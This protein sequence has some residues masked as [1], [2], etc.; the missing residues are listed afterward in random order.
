MN[1]EK[2]GDESFMLKFNKNI[3]DF[4]TIEKSLEAYS[5]FMFF[6]FDE[7]ETYFKLTIKSLDTNFKTYT[8]CLEF[9][10]Y[11]IGMIKENG[12]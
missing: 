7:N 6:E 8:L 1:F 10:N 5:D 4:K 2:T 3:Y 11:V 12:L 9:S